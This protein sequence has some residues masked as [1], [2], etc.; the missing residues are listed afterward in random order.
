MKW[1]PLLVLA[2]LSQDPTAIDPRDLGPA[3]RPE[4]RDDRA[5]YVGTFVSR[6]AEGEYFT[7]LEVGG[8][9]FSAAKDLMGGVSVLLVFE[10]RVEGGVLHQTHVHMMD[11][12][13][14]LTPTGDSDAQVRLRNGNFETYLTPVGRWR[15]WERVS[16]EE[17]Y[18]RV[19]VRDPGAAEQKAD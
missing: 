16:R 5:A 19:G 15:F 18:R 8:K 3:G 9:G 11:S 14:Q 4:S 7:A 2:L 10:W 6:D 12:Q 17:F 1:T 13:R